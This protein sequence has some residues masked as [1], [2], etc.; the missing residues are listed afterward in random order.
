MDYANS[1]EEFLTLRQAM[2]PDGQ[3][4]TYHFM[5]PSNWIN[6]PHGLIKWN[7][8]YHLFY[9]YNPNGPYHGSIH[10]GHAVSDDL[11][12]WR[13][14][15][16]ALAPDPNSYDPDGCW[17]GCTVDN[18]GVP[19]IFYTAA[20]PQTIAAAV[21]HDDMLTWQK[22]AENPLIDGPPPEIRPFAGGHFRDPLIWPAPGG[23]EMILVSKIEGE[24]GQVLLYSSPDLMEWQYRGIF[25]GGDAGQMEPF[26][27]GTMWECPNLLDFG[28]KQ[29]LIVSVQSTPSDHLYTVYFS[30]R[31]LGDRFEPEVP[32]MLVHGSSFY[33]PQAMHLPDGRFFMFGWLHEE[34]SQQACQEAGWNGSHSLPIVIDL[35][36]DGTAAL[37]PLA[38]LQML[39][40]D[41]WHREQFNLIDEAERIVDGIAGKALEIQAD[42]LPHGDAQFGIKLLSSPDEEEQTCIG[43]DHAAGQLFIERDRASLDQRANVNPATMPVDLGSGEALRLQ[44]FIDHSII[45]LFANG[46]LCLACRV[47]PT[48]D[49]SDGVRFFS[50]RGHTEVSNINIWK[51]N[52]IWP[53]DAPIRRGEANR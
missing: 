32:G 29:L 21:S 51:M 9:Q 30:G 11:V 7:G 3:R 23:W 5:P 31:R 2:A 47:Y 19:T 46:R 14:W 16:I 24:G 35:L 18:N 49:D 52:A 25:L 12:H 15:P 36:E 45:E 17:S 42:F 13:D 10:W 53:T 22:L 48:R 4:P 38:E 27:Q 28:E 39:R 41:H 33:A 26:W 44:I 20:Y 8:L 43:Y 37:S 40:G 1:E 34:R 6:D 50:R